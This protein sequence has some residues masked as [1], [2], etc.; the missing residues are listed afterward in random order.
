RHLQLNGRTHAVVGVLPAG[1]AFP[2]TGVELYV[3]A[4]FSEMELSSPAG[5]FLDGAV[6]RLA[7]GVSADAATAEADGILRR[8][9]ESFADHRGVHGATASP[10]QG[11]FLKDY[12]SALLVLVASVGFVLLIACANVA[13]LLL[14]RAAE[15]RREIAVRAALGAAR[16]RLVRQ[17]LTEST[18]L[19]L[20]GGAWGLLV[21]LWGV[22]LVVRLSPRDVPRIESV[23]VDWAVFA[24]ASAISL[25]AGLLFGVVPALEASRSRVERSLHETTRGEASGSRDSRSR[26]FLVS[27]EVALALVLLVGAGLSLRSFWILGKESPGFEPD[28]VLTARLVLPDTKY[29]EGAAQVD[30]GKRLLEE[31]RALPGVRSASLIAPMPLTSVGFGLTIQI[32]DREPPADGQPLSSNWRAVT[33]GYFSTMGIPLLAGRDIEES[34]MDLSEHDGRSVLVV[35]ETFA[36]NVFP[37]E[38]PLGKSVRI[39]YD[40]LLCEI[41]GVVGDVRHED[42]ATASGEEMYT[43]FWA[44]PLPEMNLALAASSDPESLT[45]SLR[46]A[47]RRVDPEQPVF[48][49]HAMRDLVRASVASRRFVMTLLLA[50]ALTALL[51]AALG[52]YSVVSYGVVQRTREIGVRVALGA[53]G[54]GIL[55]LVLEQGLAMA[56]TGALL[57]LASAFLL[58]RFLESQLYG[59][60][61][62]DFGT[63]AV[64][65]GGL[66]LV[67]LGATAFPAIRASRVDPIIALR[68]E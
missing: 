11:F 1:F 49:I 53:S 27:L 18:L 46:E 28:H 23:A 16:A 22:D 60:S 24:F 41:V 48:G 52:I 17:L 12:H 8:A 37:G 26:N 59:V 45:A 31:V 38:D 61:A 39:G 42:L 2:T 29:P 64:V 20:L 66:V 58:S 13:N 36:R 14:V 33:P 63:Y 15:R 40:D 7:P 30:F 56:G 32:P 43:P 62:T 4:A 35:N 10:L 50:F 34:D 3:P 55:R 6:G 65:S 57:G 51:L 54:P 44:T 67:A 68:H 25:G 5:H 47:V 19:S 9:V 21:A